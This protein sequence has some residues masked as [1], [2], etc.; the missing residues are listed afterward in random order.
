[1]RLSD[2]D[3]EKLYNEFLDEA[4]PT[5]S[6]AGLEYSTSDALKRIDPT[7]YRCGFADWLDA[8]VSNET[9]F[10]VEGEYFDE[11]PSGSEGDL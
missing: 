10:E 8:E 3:L 9:I 11:D 5:C 2:R 6:I 4:Y 7:A 1:M